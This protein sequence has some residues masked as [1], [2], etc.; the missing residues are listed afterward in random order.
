MVS[1]EEEEK[2]DFKCVKQIHCLSDNQ[3]FS[4]CKREAPGSF[5]ALSNELCQSLH[6][7]C[8]EIRVKKVM[9]FLENKE[10][11]TN[12]KTELIPHGNYH[13]QVENQITEDMINFTV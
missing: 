10:T 1:K 7:I 8:K 9:A 4:F 12:K 5:L 13:I 11:M 2:H 3:T 6:S